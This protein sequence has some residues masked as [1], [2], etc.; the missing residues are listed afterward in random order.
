MTWNNLKI[1]HVNYYWKIYNQL[2]SHEEDKEKAK[3]S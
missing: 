3:H 2:L 1:T